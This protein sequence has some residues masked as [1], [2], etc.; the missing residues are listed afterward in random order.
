MDYPEGAS[1]LHIFTEKPPS[2][3]KPGHK[4]YKRSTD[5]SA[6]AAHAKVPCFYVKHSTSL[7]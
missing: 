5:V 2:P 1:S 3:R 6:F 4:L 7:L